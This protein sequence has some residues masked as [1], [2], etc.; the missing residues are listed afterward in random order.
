MNRMDQLNLR[1]RASL[2]ADAEFG[3]WPLLL[4]PL[5]KKQ[6]PQQAGPTPPQ[7]DYP[8][9]RRP[10]PAPPAPLLAEVIKALKTNQ[11]DQA[12]EEDMGTDLVLGADGNAYMVDNYG[13][14]YGQ[15]I[16]L[17]RGPGYN[18]PGRY[19]ADSGDMMGADEDFGADLSDDDP[20][21]DFGAEDLC[22]ETIDDET[23]EDIGYGLDIPRAQGKLEELKTAAR[24][25]ENRI[26]QIQNKP[27]FFKEKRIAAQMRKLG[28]IKAKVAEIQGQIK[29]EKAKRA[30]IRR[31]AAGLADF[32]GR[33]GGG[34]QGGGGGQ[35]RVAAPGSVP[36]S[37]GA[38][39]MQ[40][41]ISAGEGDRIRNEQARQGLVHANLRAPPGSGR[42]LNVPMLAS[43]S[44]TNRTSTTIAA[45]G[46]MQNV[47]QLTSEQVPYS[48]YKIVGFTA[49]IKRSAT[50]AAT[51]IQ[52]ETGCLFVSNLQVKG[53][54][55]LF[56]HDSKQDV[57]EYDTDHEH[58]IGLRAYPNVVSPN[59]ATVT[60]DAIA[61]FQDV[62]LIGCFNLVVDQVSDDTFGTG[63]PGAYAG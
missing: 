7:A 48:V 57:D 3:F 28:K 30:K 10:L 5:L 19:G 31:Q 60:V 35:A 24:Q 17:R 63:V 39:T 11:Q 43:G 59:Q 6:Q 1:F 33:Q 12:P 61:N 49:Q 37:R 42:L 53:W 26:S 2:G 34:R 40:R 44:T 16:A 56:L 38:Q 52:A 23:G 47:G 51:A 41:T 18:P 50:G 8:P 9:P 36:G 58:L 21:L 55:N 46:V 25:V 45:A 29:A 13:R 32:D 4:A 22:G 62:I 27:G 20:S 54:P 14:P 15:P